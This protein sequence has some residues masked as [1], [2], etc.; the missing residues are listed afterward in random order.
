MLPQALE[1]IDSALIKTRFPDEKRQQINHL[2]IL[3]SGKINT[4]N[5]YNQYLTRQNPLVSALHLDRRGADGKGE[6]MRAA[7]V[8]MERAVREMIAAINGRI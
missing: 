7:L 2:R 1:F 3:N 6:K 8:G 5:Q 4:L